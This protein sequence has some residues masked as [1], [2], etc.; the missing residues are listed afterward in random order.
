[1]FASLR[2]DRFV[3]GNHQQHKINAAHS[4]QHVAHKALVSGHVDKPQPQSFAAGHGQLKIGKADIDGDAATL[5]FLQ[6]VGI[7]ASQCLHQCGFAVIDVTRRA[8][9]DRFH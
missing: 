5:F 2:L 1:M 6:A 9:D 4:S 7:D 3:G 8:Y